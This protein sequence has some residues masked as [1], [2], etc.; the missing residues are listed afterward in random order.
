MYVYACDT[1]SGEPQD[2][3]TKVFPTLKEVCMERP[4]S[5]PF[6]QKF[7]LNIY[8]QV[9]QLVPESVIFNVEVKY[10]LPKQVSLA[11]HW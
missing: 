8:L 9:L 11:F 7:V 3:R 1:G 4:I 5:V 2:V 10:P 6:V